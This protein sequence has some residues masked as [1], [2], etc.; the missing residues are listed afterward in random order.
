M[1][2]SSAKAFHTC[3]LLLFFSISLFSFCPS[4]S[5]PSAYLSCDIYLVTACVVCAAGCVGWLWWCDVCTSVC[6][7]MCR[8]WD[9]FTQMSA[10]VLSQL[11]TSMSLSLLYLPSTSFTVKHAE[12]HGTTTVA[13][14]QI[15]LQPFCAL[16]MVLCPALL[17]G[18]CFGVDERSLAVTRP[19]RVVSDSIIYPW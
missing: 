5:P 9:G 14:R 19:E 8:R 17:S 2:S 15:W 7:Y 16:Q 6:V 18:C 10:Y 12:P 13:R 11:A 1:V 3:L 4:L